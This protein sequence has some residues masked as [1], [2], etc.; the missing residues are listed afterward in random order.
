MAAF[1]SAL[2]GVLLVGS[3]Y[4]NGKNFYT[5]WYTLLVWNIPY[6]R[7][8]ISFNI[9]DSHKTC[10]LKSVSMLIAWRYINDILQFAKN[11]YVFFLIFKC[12]GDTCDLQLKVD[13]SGSTNYYFEG[14]Y[15]IDEMSLCFGR[16]IWSRN[17]DPTTYYIFYSTGYWVIS[18]KKCSTEGKG[19]YVNSL[20]CPWWLVITFSV[21]KWSF[22]WCL[23]LQLCFS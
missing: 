15:F 19:S 9:I 10:V 5:S 8:P 7:L 6:N 12:V 17:T 4:F 22:A 18:N 16:P 21:N 3:V 2:M 13:V 1:F 20:I 11:C 14:G 23:C